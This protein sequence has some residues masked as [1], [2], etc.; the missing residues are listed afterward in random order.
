MRSRRDDVDWGAAVERALAIGVVGMGEPT[1]E[2]AAARLEPFAAAPGDS[3]VWTRSA[4]GEYF[5]GRITGPARR[6]GSPEAAE[7]DLVHVRPCAWQPAPVDVVPP[8]VLHTFGRGGRNWQQIHDDA[9]FE[10]SAQV[11]ASH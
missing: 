4:D 11:L 5:A 10:Q 7:V 6:D 1:E 2:R 9:V 8:A 3:I